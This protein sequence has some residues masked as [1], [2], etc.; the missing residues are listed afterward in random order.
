LI[1]LEAAQAALPPGHAR[2]LRGAG[3]LDLARRRD[4]CEP[5]SCASL[6]TKKQIKSGFYLLYAV[7][8]LR[9]KAVEFLSYCR[10]WLAGCVKQ[11]SRADFHKFVA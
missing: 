10:A 3:F 4:E 7:L 9:E 2:Q 1:E 6:Q 5:L 11:I 8:Y